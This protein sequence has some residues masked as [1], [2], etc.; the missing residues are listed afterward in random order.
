MP[1]LQNRQMGRS[2]ISTTLSWNPQA[3]VRARYITG[4]RAFLYGILH[5]TREMP[6]TRCILHGNPILNKTEGKD[7]EPWTFFFFMELTFEASSG[8]A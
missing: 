3:R 5:K 1:F 4:T 8:D 2:A 6:W 7:H